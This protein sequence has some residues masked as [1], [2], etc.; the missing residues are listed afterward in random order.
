MD[1]SRVF[2]S[3]N[4]ESEGFMKRIISV[5]L[6]LALLGCQEPETV[7]QFTGNETTYELAAGSDYNINGTVTFK[8]RFDG[9]TTVIIQLKGTDGAVKHPV[10]LHLGNIATPK[11]DVAALLSPVSASTGISETLLDRLAD[12]T[13]IRYIDL[14]AIEA[15]IKIHLA[16]SGDGRDVI[17]AG[18]NIGAAYIKG[19]SSGRSTGFAICK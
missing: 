17:L 7:S 19:L 16:D 14:S 1:C 2:I 6:L 9:F 5:L 12:D 3:F 15:C 18:G 10:H 11:A 4:A 13:P 8:E